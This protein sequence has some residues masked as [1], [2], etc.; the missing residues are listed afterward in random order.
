MGRLRRGNSDLFGGAFTVRTGCRLHSG[1]SV[2]MLSVGPEP[3]MEIP[4]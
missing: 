1:R 4:G 3:I 2:G